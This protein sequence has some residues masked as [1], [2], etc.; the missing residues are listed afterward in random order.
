MIEWYKQGRF[1]VDK[2]ITTF[3][4]SDINQAVAAATE[5]RAI[6]PVLLMR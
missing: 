6:K 1:P 5:G 2:L 4:F 3:D